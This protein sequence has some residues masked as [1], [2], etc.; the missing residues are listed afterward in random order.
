MSQDSWVKWFK[1]PVIL[2]KRQSC[3]PFLLVFFTSNYL[4]FRHYYKQC[5][6]FFRLIFPTTCFIAYKCNWYFCID[7]YFEHL[8]N[9]CFGLRVTVRGAWRTSMCTFLLSFFYLF[10][11]SHY[12]HSCVMLHKNYRNGH[13]FSFTN[14]ISKNIHSLSLN[15]LI[16]GFVRSIKLHTSAILLRCILNHKLALNLRL[17]FYEKNMSFFSFISSMVQLWLSN[18]ETILFICKKGPALQCAIQLYISR[19]NF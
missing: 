19:V 16:V 15:V 7:P 12:I 1:A 9:S 2:Y 14:I 13:P 10:L 17:C 5:F 11:L 8:L 4:R 18:A 6:Y 3:M